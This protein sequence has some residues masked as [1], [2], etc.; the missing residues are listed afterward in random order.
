MKVFSNI[1][2]TPVKNVYECLDVEDDK[3]TILLAILLQNGSHEKNSNR[4]DACTQGQYVDLM[5]AEAANANIQSK[6]KSL[7]LN[8]LRD[9]ERA[10]EKE[11][12]DQNADDLAEKILLAP[13]VYYAAVMM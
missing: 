5:S 7:L 11:F 9:Q 1:L 12:Q 4:V 13:D 8:R 10:I 3:E 6:L 2:G